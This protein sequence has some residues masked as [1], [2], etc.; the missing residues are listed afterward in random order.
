ME[1]DILVILMMAF[2]LFA[3]LMFILFYIYAKKYYNEKH[4][5]E[6]YQEDEECEL[7]DIRINDKVIVFDSNNYEL[8]TNDH[9][10]VIIDNN[11]Y[12]G[13]VEKGN[14]KELLSNIK[15]TP[16]LL[17]I[18]NSSDI[19][20]NNL[21]FSSEESITVVPNSSLDNEE[22][23]DKTEMLDFDDIDFIPKKKN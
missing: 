17:V 4:L 6:D 10:K 21:E 20:E 19:N 16:R 1:K 3:I 7:I 22:K 18:D 9:V 5:T 12:D 15:D 14:Y 11:I 23:I 13:L 2:G 8:S